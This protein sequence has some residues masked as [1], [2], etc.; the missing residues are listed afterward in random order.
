MH[1]FFLA[2]FLVALP[3]A[4][5]AATLAPS[6][7]VATPSSYDGHTL[8]VTGTVSEF[9]TKDTA[10]GDFTKFSLCDSKCILV[11]DKTSQP[12]ADSTSATVTGTFH[13]SYKG[14]K[15]QWTNVLTIGF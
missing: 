8:T 4:A 12:H 9:K 11:V 14:P 3:I 7:I 2:V 5:V 10:M 13:E 6:V 15:K 1:R